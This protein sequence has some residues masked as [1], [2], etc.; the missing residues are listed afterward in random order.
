ML[1]LNGWSWAPRGILFPTVC[2]VL[3]LAGTASAQVHG[4][5]RGGMRVDRENRGVPVALRPFVAVSG[6]YSH[7]LTP[8]WPGSGG[9]VYERSGYGY[10][11]QA[12][13]VG[14][15]DWQR[16]SLFLDYRAVYGRYSRDL[17]QRG[18]DHFLTLGY[19]A[20]LTRRTSVYLTQ[21]AGAV[22]RNLGPTG[23]L[24]GSGGFGGG[25][26]FSFGLSDPTVAFGPEYDLYDTRTYY[27]S[28]GADL[29]FQKSPRLSFNG[30][31][32]GFIIR[33]PD[34]GLSD[35]QGY[36]AR[37]DITYLLTRHQSV[38]V[39]YGYLQYDFRQAFGS[40]QAHYV[41]AGFARQLARHVS[42]SISGGVYRLDANVIMRVRLDPLV[43][44]LLGQST[45]LEIYSGSS[46]GTVFSAR[47]MA[48]FHHSSAALAY[49]R[50]M[51]PGNGIYLTSRTDT[52]AGSYTLSGRTRWSFSASAGYFRLSPAIQVAPVL[53]GYHAGASAGYRLTRALHLSSGY[54]VR[55]YDNGRYQQWSA[56][57]HAGLTF[58]PGT[59]P[60]STPW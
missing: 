40:S 1:Q 10:S 48:G 19:S 54:A 3:A 32:S 56:V 4:L 7:G 2:I 30:G 58:A 26:G 23:L 36:T 34:A 29:T 42:G 5:G 47:L 53:Q 60:L 55:R 49:H 25:G 31:G 24:M 27:L 20:D 22:S 8:A 43:A 51:L 9:P 12:G 13:A 28:S 6:Q 17:G 18:V 38:S 46:Y 50:R 35:S 57:A 14:S 15:H 21:Y 52:L 11:A 39:Q 44:A 37:G 41:A 33:R 45:G 16:S 59:L